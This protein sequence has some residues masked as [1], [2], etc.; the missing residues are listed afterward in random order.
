LAIFH[1]H[2]SILSSRHYLFLCLLP[3]GSSPRHPFSGSARRQ[4]GSSTSPR[5]G[6]RRPGSRHP[7]SSLSRHQLPACFS[8]YCTSRTAALH[9][10]CPWRPTLL[11]GVGRR[12]LGS[13]PPMAPSSLGPIARSSARAERPF[14]VAAS[15]CSL[16]QS[17]SSLPQ[18]SPQAAPSSP[19]RELHFSEP[20]KLLLMAPPLPAT[21]SLSLLSPSQ[22]SQRRGLLPHGG[23][24]PC[25][26]P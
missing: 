20:P 22:D 21:S 10:P 2:P 13:S 12:E 24:A 11:H 6:A 7:S 4:A 23:R 5:H 16:L 8:L 19:W 3:H 9:A 14:P 25:S 17:R 26:Q 15:L 1:S 18:P